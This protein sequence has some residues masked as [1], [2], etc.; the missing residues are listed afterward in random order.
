MSKKNKLNT[1]DY[2][3]KKL[4]AFD[5]YGTCIHRQKQFFGKWFSLWKE[6][7]TILET[8][9]IDFDQINWGKIE[10]NWKL[11]KLK[12]GDIKN[13]KKDI[14]WILLYPDFEGV[15]EY[16]K[17]KWYKTAVISNLAKPYEEP[18]RRLIPEWSF[19]YEALSFNARAMKPNPEIFEFLKNLSWLEF[20]EMILVWDSLKSDI[21]WANDVWIKPIHINR[22]HKSSP[23]NTKKD[24]IEFIQISTLNQL[25][26]IL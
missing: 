21:K 23:E 8:N 18:M 10:F 16:L 15:I 26:N 20:N 6:L 4:V 17:S 1:D 14:A 19:D 7:K 22:W 2:K 24:W 13:I 9:P 25:K 11:F 3:D 12:S 5:L